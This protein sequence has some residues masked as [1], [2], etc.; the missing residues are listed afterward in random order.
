MENK[1]MKKITAQWTGCG[2]TLCHGEWVFEIDGI[3]ISLDTIKE[4]GFLSEKIEDLFK[5]HM[6]TLKEYSYW[7]FT[8]DW[9]VEWESE[10]EGLPFEEWIKSSNKELLEKVFKTF[11]IEL[12]FEEWA[13]LYN[14]INE[15]DW[16]PGTCG[17][18]I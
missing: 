3:E 10:E 5:M 14:E 13:K 6:D 7:H 16:R 18:C 11:D 15:E 8:D 17:G 12:S 4:K 9:D 1:K 2:P